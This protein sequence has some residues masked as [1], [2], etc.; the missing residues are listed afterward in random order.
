[1]GV[2]EFYHGLEDKYY[3][4]LDWL[5]KHGI[6]VYSVVDAIEAQNIPS[7]PIAALVVLLAVG[8]LFTFILPGIFG[9]S[10]TLNVLVQDETQTPLQGIAV[11]LS[12]S[13]LSGDALSKRLTDSEGVVTFTNLPIGASVTVSADHDTYAIDDRSIVLDQGENERKLTAIAIALTKS[14]SLQLYKANSTESFVNAIPLSFACSGDTAFSKSSTV[15]N[16]QI[17]IDVPPACGTLSVQSL[18]NTLSLQ[19]TVIDVDDA[20]PRV[21]VNAQPAG[22]GVLRVTLVNDSGTGIAGMTTYLKSKFGDVIATKFSDASGFVEYTGIVPDTY[23]VFVAADGTY[24]ELDSGN[25]EVSETEPVV[26]TFTVPLASVGEVRLQLVDEGNLSPV[27]GAKVTLSRG[28]QVVGTK[29]TNEG[30]QVTFSVSSPNSLTVAVDHP[31][32]LVRSGISVGVSAAGYTQIPLA[33]ATLNN[34]QIVTVKVVDELNQPVENAYVALKKS[35]SGASIGTNKITGASGTVQFTSLE[36]GTYFASAYKPGFSDQIKSD[37]FSV[38]ARENVESTIKLVIGTGTVSF[39]VNDEGG[40]PLAGATIQAIDGTTHDAVGNEIATGVD[41][42]AELTLRADRFVYFVISEPNHLPY[43][44]LPVQVRKSIT[45]NVTA[46]L[47]RDIARLEI[48]TLSTSVNGK[49]ILE[50]S[51]L[52]PGQTYTVRFALLVPRNTAYS[53]TGVHVRTG[54]SIEGQTNPIENDGWYIRDVRSA[55]AKLQKGTTYTPSEGLGIDSQ[56]VTSSDAKWAN[57]VFTP[58]R[59]GLTI[60]EVDVTVK[61]STA[62]GADLPLYYRA[63]GR[64]GSYVRFPVDAVLGGSESVA[65]KQGLYANAN[66]K[67]YSP[68]ASSHVCSKD[69]CLGLVSE[70]LSTGIQNNVA[71][72]VE[73]DISS[74]QKL[75]FTFTSISDSVFADTSLILQSTSTSA[76]LQAYDVTNA[77]GAKKT[78]V[79]SG[80]KVEIP[81]GTIQKNNVAFGF[82]N[83]DAA[84]EGTARVKF[85]LVSNK[86][87]VYTRE[88]LVRVNAAGIMNVEIVP[89][90]ILPLLTNQLLVHVTQS[91]SGDDVAL[92]NASVNITLNGILLTSGYTDGEGVFPFELNEPNV[93]DNVEITASK[94]GFKPVVKNI[95]VGA[96]I[97]AFLPTQLNESLIVNGTTRKTKD[98]HM[99]NLASIPLTIKEVSLSGDFEGLVR[100]DLLNEELVGEVLGVN[101][102]R[103]VTVAFSLTDKGQNLLVGKTLKGSVLVKLSSDTSGKT[104]TN[105]LPLT[106]KIGFGGEVDVEDCLL[107]EPV[108]WDV[109]ADPQEVKQ[110]AF[111]IKNTCTVNAVP[112]RLTNFSAKIKQLSGDPLGTFSATTSEKTVELSSGFK[113]ILNSLP[114]GEETIV[115]VS[116]SPDVIQSGLATPELVFQ[117]TNMTSTGIPDFVEENVKVNL[118]V[119]DLS[120]CVKINAPSVLEIDS[121]AIN[122]GA[123]QMGNYYNQV[124]RPTGVPYYNPSYST[125]NNTTNPSGSS[126]LPSGVSG[127]MFGSYNFGSGPFSPQY[128]AS[129]Y[130]GFGGYQQGGAQ[131]SGVGGYSSMQGYYANP[132]V[133]RY[134]SVSGA[135][136]FFGCGNSEIRIENS[137]QSDIE[138]QLDADPNVQVSKTSVVLKPNQNERI[139][140]GSGYRIGKYPIFVNARAAG[141]KDASFEVASVDVLIKSPTE[142]NA[143][144]IGLNTTKFRFQELIQKPVKGKVI[145]KCYNSGVRLIPS[146]DTVTIAS[147]FNVDDQ[148]TLTDKGAA[149]SRPNSMAHDIQLIGVQTRGEGR[150]TIQE[151]EFQIFPDFETYK[152]VLSPFTQNAGLG[153]QILDLKFFLEGQYYRAESYGTIS[154]KYLD[155]YGGSQQKP[156]PVIFENLFRIAGVLDIGD[157]NP[158]LTDFQKCINNDVL[159][160]ETSAGGTYVFDDDD[161][162]S[163]A[164]VVG[165]RLVFTTATPRTVL[166]ADDDHC[167]G[168]DYLSN[169]V[170]DRLVSTENPNVTAEFRVV[171]SRNIQVTVTRPLTLQTDATIK[172]RLRMKLTRTAFNTSTQDVFVDV[173]FKVAKPGTLTNISKFTPLVCTDPSS[174]GSLSGYEK[175]AGFSGKYGFDMISWKW[176]YA[177]SPSCETMFCDATQLSIWL[178][179]K[180]K[181]FNEFLMQNSNVFSAVSGKVYRTQTLALDVLKTVPAVKDQSFSPVKEYQFAEAGTSFL[182][183]PDTGA[184]GELKKGITLNM[185]ELFAKSSD[186]TTDEAYVQLMS[187]KLNTIE[188]LLAPTGNNAQ[189]G[190]V[191]IIFNPKKLGAAGSAAVQLFGADSFTLGG[192]NKYVMTFHEYKEFHQRMVDVSFT[193]ATGVKVSAINSS[194]WTAIAT[195]SERSTVTA[196][197]AENRAQGNEPCV[198]NSNDIKVWM[199]PNLLKSMY[200][201]IER[202]DVA[203]IVPTA[204][205]LTNDLTKYLLERATKKPLFTL[206]AYNGSMDRLTSEFL[207]FSGHLMSDTINTDLMS[208]LG[209]VS[210]A[211]YEYSTNFNHPQTTANENDVMKRLRFKTSYSTSNTD[212]FRTI[213][214]PGRYP[215]AFEATWDKGSDGVGTITL[216]I[217]ESGR[218]IQEGVSRATLD[219]LEAEKS[220]SGVTLAYSENPFFYLPFNGSTGLTTVR[221][222]YGTSYA[223]RANGKLELVQGSATSANTS[224]SLNEHTTLEQLSA[225]VTTRKQPVLL[226]V[227][228]ASKPYTINL[229]PSIPVGVRADVTNP[230]GIAS[231]QYG[232]VRVG[233]ETNFIDASPILWSDCT[234][235][236]SQLVS[237]LDQATCNTAI[238]N[239]TTIQ[240]SI[241]GNENFYTGIAL[242]PDNTYAMVPACAV[243]NAVILGEGQSPTQ[244]GRTVQGLGEPLRLNNSRFTTQSVD[245][246]Q[247]VINL[248]TRGDACGK[249]DGGLTA[250]WDASSERVVPKTLQCGSPINVN[251]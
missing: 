241:S 137:C 68:G 155:A 197:E 8:G 183:I 110:Q 29:T 165:T 123:G 26:K 191:V 184:Y 230:S 250:I 80:N 45:Q 138:I 3:A 116:F 159:Q 157:G 33:K 23:V 7:F 108:Q 52:A 126:L 237:T 212:D 128:G 101:Q 12:G 58:A 43:V 115:T 2:Q 199:T 30:G 225:F 120:S 46:E 88:V 81:L 107:V 213:A 206:E 95:S 51:G 140:V 226:S 21:Y 167:G 188:T 175:G 11:Q 124:Y 44:T 164:G 178:N 91:V 125:L 132:L 4:G 5:D 220:A 16:G 96:D 166:I 229:A 65:Q 216:T 64:T 31:T 153:Q 201:G 38:R 106:I 75:L 121:C 50:E 218:I 18:D 13:G 193:S 189:L 227:E 235:S 151:L 174:G 71:D 102:D 127:G 144:C 10:A 136:A 207:F 223:M 192:Q 182:T 200:T 117:A 27:S 158:N 134:N 77:V 240:G 1:M 35:P 70:D 248:I 105:A 221:N 210:E 203:L 208:D 99:L 48:K 228:G 67:L 14:I 160:F 55:Y 194:A 119:N 181:T 40:Q 202:V 246:L 62:Q 42:K 196:C 186:G 59:E 93:N 6:P 179:K 76:T 24:G 79:V 198:V 162:R 205:K 83:V 231:M 15:I 204:D 85:S 222:G 92:E 61:D 131:F 69:F 185:D 187:E 32:Y 47:V 195:N 9:G 172:G 141:S 139:R 236:T 22:N 211:G 169:I 19:N 251:A 146:A 74:K 78:G 17:T 82:V 215:M 25:I 122:T 100:F 72:D 54:N 168:K 209:A 86:Q 249:L 232:F 214:T 73:A 39:L 176:D 113:N 156:F 143:D 224:V 180:I 20:N 41:G 49:P 238:A 130:D 34:S 84:K 242:V 63:W 112:V 53:E 154:V 234:R 60:V 170:N 239:Q 190:E 94:Q 244:V 145:N 97:V 28:N 171:D 36:E 149:K 98:I 247:D 87:E 118:V 233:A 114:A 133:D 66:V 90:A 111:A 245:T 103:N 177:N 163:D 129:G 243:D 147:Y 37:L 135:G 161:F 89:R 173:S 104:F 152:R 150:D 56:H 217:Q 109:Y 57:I 219:E 148:I 142:V